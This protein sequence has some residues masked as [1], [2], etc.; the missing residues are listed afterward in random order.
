[1]PRYA[2]FSLGVGEIN[3][4]WSWGAPVG[5]LSDEGDGNRYVCNGQSFSYQGDANSLDKYWWGAAGDETA[6]IPYASRRLGCCT[7][8]RGAGAASL[9]APETCG[10]VTREP[11]LRTGKLIGDIEGESDE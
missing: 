10:R 1:M 11:C 9:G 6:L 2:Q 7:A 3:W 8:A 5:V 4:I